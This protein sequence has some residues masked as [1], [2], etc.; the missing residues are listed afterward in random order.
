M[1]SFDLYYLG[2]NEPNYSEG[3]KIWA[4]HK[5]DK[6]ILHQFF[7]LISFNS[8]LKF[9]TLYPQFPPAWCYLSHTDHMESIPSEEGGVVPPSWLCSRVVTKTQP[10]SLTHHPRGMIMGTLH[11]PS[12]LGTWATLFPACWNICSSCNY[13]G[14][15][16]PGVS[17]D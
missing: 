8:R 4:H 2:Q 11:L 16:P 15:S 10:H 14:S 13:T 7:I 9:T 3:E 6:K 12:S 5:K 17:T 1:S